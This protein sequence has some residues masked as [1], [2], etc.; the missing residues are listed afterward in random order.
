MSK[1]KK[2]IIAVECC[3]Q[4]RETKRFCSHV[5]QGGYG[6]KKIAKAIGK[7]LLLTLAN[8]ISIIVFFLLGAILTDK[9]LKVRQQEQFFIGLIIIFV[10]AI[11]MTR[12]LYYKIIKT[13]GEDGKNTSV[14][15]RIS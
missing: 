12:F 2:S 6:F 3:K 1:T 13:G 7:F 8:L 11:S 5:S 10:F 14:N 9:V 4:Q 15:M